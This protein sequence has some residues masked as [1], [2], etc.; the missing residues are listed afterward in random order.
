MQECV[1][2]WQKLWMRGIET[3]AVPMR[4]SMGLAESWGHRTR[5]GLVRSFEAGD[6]VLEI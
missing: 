1:A 4:T 2:G 5:L 6:S 3:Y